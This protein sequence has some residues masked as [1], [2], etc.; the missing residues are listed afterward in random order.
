[1]AEHHYHD[2]EKISHTEAT[3]PVHTDPGHTDSGLIDPGQQKHTPG[4]PAKKK[5][6]FMRGS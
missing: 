3:D 6:R 1:M 4:K 5:S 2:R